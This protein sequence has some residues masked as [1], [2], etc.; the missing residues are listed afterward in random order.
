FS[1]NLSNSVNAL[2]GTASAAGVIL[3]EE[4]P[5]VLAIAAVSGTQNEG[6]TGN[7]SFEFTVTRTGDVSVA[8]SADFAVT[9]SGGNPANAAD[10]GGTL[11]S[12]TIYFAAGETTQTIL[13]AVSG[14]SQLE[15][16]EG[17]SISL[18]NEVMA[19]L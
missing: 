5:P 10:F 16:N 11:P 15:P 19:D 4:L 3:S 18:L 17:F 12:G 6:H 8:S 9:G 2:L 1:I 14:D 7:T 13:V